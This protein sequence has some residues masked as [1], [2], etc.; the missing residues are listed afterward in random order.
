MIRKHYGEVK[1]LSPHK[2]WKPVLLTGFY[3][4][5]LMPRN[6]YFCTFISGRL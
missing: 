4:V 2:I 6:F 5:S 1:G 3:P